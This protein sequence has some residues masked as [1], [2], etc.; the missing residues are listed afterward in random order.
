MW[1]DWHEIVFVNRGLR[2]VF[3]IPHEKE[4]E[5]VE[6]LFGDDASI[7]FITTPGQVTLSPCLILVCKII[8]P[9]KK[10]W[11]KI[12]GEILWS[13]DKKL[14]IK[15]SASALAPTLSPDGGSSPSSLDLGL[16]KGIRQE[17]VSEKSPHSQNTF[18]LLV[19]MQDD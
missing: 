4:R 7:V 12:C 6:E 16:A 3:V 1:K 15:P 5:N 9:N 8:L 11:Q 19:I 14:Q 13:E 10:N 17:N 2:P 18:S